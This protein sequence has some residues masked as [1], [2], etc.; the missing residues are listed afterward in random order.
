[1]NKRKSN[2][3]NSSQNAK[4][5]R[6]S[7]PDLEENIGLRRS[8]RSTARKQI[9]HKV[10]ES[11]ESSSDNDDSSS[12]EFIVASQPSTSGTLVQPIN[13]FLSESSS[14]EDED[15]KAQQRPSSSKRGPNKYTQDSTSSESSGDDFQ[16]HDASL[17]RKKA[18]QSQSSEFDAIEKHILVGVT[19]RLSDDSDIE[20]NTKEESKPFIP[21]DVLFP[22]LKEKVDTANAALVSDK[23]KDKK[24]LQVKMKELDVS[25]LLALGESQ[26]VNEPS[27]SSTPPK[28]EQKSRSKRPI[29]HETKSS[30]SKTS[31]AKRD[32][33]KK[34]AIKEEVKSESEAS[35]WEEVEHKEEHKIPKEGVEVTVQLPDIVKK[36]KKKSVDMAAIIKRRINQIKRDNQVLI[37]KV[38]LLC[39]LS[40]G[41]H[42][43]RILNSPSLMGLALSLIPSQHCYPPRQV[44]LDYLEKITRWFKKTINVGTESDPLEKTLLEILEDCFHTKKAFNKRI[45][46]FLFVSMMRSLGLKTRLI[47]NMQP[48][49]LKLKSEELCNVSQST[50]SKDKV[51][52]DKKKS[53]KL[54]TSPVKPKTETSKGQSSNS[55]SSSSKKS[56]KSKHVQV[57]NESESESV[58]VKSTK[59]STSKVKSNKQIAKNSPNTSEY[60]EKSSKYFNDSN[61]KSKINLK[62]V[63]QSSNDKKATTRGVT[64]CSN[65]KKAPEASTSRNTRIKVAEQ[66]DKSKRGSEPR[67]LRQRRPSKY[68]DDSDSEKDT[69]K[70]SSKVTKSTEGKNSKIKNSEM[71]DDSDFKPEVVAV[72]KSLTSR[73]IDRRVLSSA[74]DEVPT[75]KPKKAKVGVDFWAEVFVEM[76]EKWICVDVPNGKIHCVPDLFAHASSPVTYVVAFG[77]DTSVRDVSKR[78]CPQFYTVTR[79]QRV[80]ADW[81]DGAIKP[82]YGRQTAH[83]REEEADMDKQ[84]QDRPLPTSIGEYKSHPLYALRRHLL[85]FEAIYPP[86]SVPLGFIRGEPVYSRDCVFTLRSR[87]TWMKEAKIVRLKEE[88]YKI[89][90]SRPKYDRMSGQMVTDKPLEIFGPWQVED[91]VPPPAVDGKVPRNEYGNV[92]LFKPTMLP[93]GAV[94]LAISGLNRIAKKLNVDCA[95]AMVGFDYHCGGCHPVFDGYVVCEEFKDLLIDAH[96]QEEEERERRHEEK[97]QKRVYGNWRRLI[98]G[99]L[100]RENLKR[101]YNFDSQDQNEAGSSSGK[102]TVKRDKKQVARK[103][104]KS[105]SSESD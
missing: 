19:T 49:P 33:L 61:I 15:T 60:F 79:K 81:W 35:D 69:K 1:M 58:K 4:K 64:P 25:Q 22:Q 99:L 71:S 50:N 55:K 20:E 32:S 8:N 12:D 100:I 96:R 2:T 40:H 70:L 41:M 67:V 36:R 6:A 27:T 94:H 80:D 103:K 45:L 46:V 13:S 101:K 105:E 68:K 44:D 53:T 77:N 102:V 91:Y 43:N 78:Y 76:E 51:S 31:S 73:V 62:S 56:T 63:N 82:F 18:P 75:V 87:E 95:P 5:H 24:I 30:K 104:K 9:H 89:V 23:K 90:K 59:Q 17:R 28:S 10:K 38:S 47:I 16:H 72:R 48:L 7:S 57:Q 54:S 65:E 26:S 88:P 98:N 97:R 37:H 52:A 21:T 66:N 42:V 74:E 14:S 92:E 86:E 93:K 11:A 29:K 84:M 3:R 83:D 85:K 34:K 39:W